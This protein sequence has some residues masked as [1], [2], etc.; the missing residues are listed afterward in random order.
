[1]G[2]TS[3]KSFV[4][5]FQFNG[6][7]QISSWRK[8]SGQS[9]SQGVWTDLS[10]APG[11]PTPNYYASSPLVAATIATQGIYVGKNV[12]PGT[13]H[14][15]EIMVCSTS[16]VSTRFILLDYLAYYSFVDQSTTDEQV[17]DNTGFTLPRYSDGVGVMMMPVLVAPQSGAVNTTM[18]VRYYDGL[19]EVDSPLVTCTN[20]TS[21]G[22]ILTSAPSTAGTC[23]PFIPLS[24]N[25]STGAVQYITSVSMGATDIGLFALALVKPIAAF[26]LLEQTAPT[27]VCFLK[28]MP[29]LPRI[30]DGAYLNLIACPAGNISGVGMLGTITTV[31]N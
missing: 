7:T 1:M 8:V 27:E 17:M 23:G 9:T 25:S 16:S 2:W 28:D 11:N 14:L 24:S 30:L 5:D 15:K 3:T 26:S 20:F 6:K 22:T 4:E 13:K 21:N 31:W 19:T 10:M 29:S 18:A 12:Y